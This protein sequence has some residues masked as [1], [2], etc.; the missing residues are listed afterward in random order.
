[1]DVPRANGD[2]EGADAANQAL[3]KKYP[4]HRRAKTAQLEAVQASMAKVI[5]LTLSSRY[6]TDSAVRAQMLAERERVYRTEVLAELDSNIGRLG[7]DAEKNPEDDAKVFERDRWEHYRLMAMLRCAKLLPEGSPEAKATYEKIVELAQKFVDT[8]FKNFGLQYEAQLV[9]GQSLGA[10]GRSQEA[11]EALELLVEVE[12]VS[13]PPYDDVMVRIIRLLRIQAV[14]GSAEAWNRAG[15]PEKAVDIFD[16][17]AKVPQPHFPWRKD[18]EDPDVLPFAVSM[19]IEEAIARLAGG[20][21]QQGV[22]KIR[23]L[24][25]RFD[26]PAFRKGNPEAADAYLL[27]IA[28]GLARAVDAGVADLP[29]ELYYRAAVGYKG[30]GR[31][32][33]A[34]RAATL[35]LDAGSGVPGEEFWLAASLY[36]IG[37]AYDSIDLPEAAALAYQTLCLDSIAKKSAPRFDVLLPDAAQNWYALAEELAAGQPGPWQEIATL[38][39][40]VFSELS[41]GEAGITLRLQKA[42]EAEDRGQ[43]DEARRLY[44]AIPRETEIDGRKKRVEAYYRARAG[45][46]R[47]GFRKAVAEGRAAEG[48]PELIAEVGPLITEARTEKDAAGEAALRFE[49]ANAHWTEP[50]RD[51]AAALAALSPLLGEVAGQNPF[52]EGGLLLWVTVLCWGNPEN[53]A[54]G[55]KPADA[56]RVLTALKGEFAESASVAIALYEMVEA[57]QAVGTTQAL[58]RAADLAIE[59]T[60]H[61]VAKF[62]EASPGVKLTIAKILVQGGEHE[63]ARLILADAEKAAGD[64]PLLRTLIVLQY[65]EAGNATGRHREVLESLEPFIAEHQDEIVMGDLE[66]APYLLFQ[67][68][69]ALVGLYEKDRKPETLVRAEKD[70]EGAVGILLQRRSSLIRTGQITPQFERDYWECYLQYLLVLQAQN[71][72]EAVLGMIQGERI[73]KGGAFAPAALQASFDQLEKDCQ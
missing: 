16:S 4:T 19:E 56:E 72:C 14:Q 37:E 8:R 57:N 1:V 26:A 50:K 49:L 23:K 40:G 42:A 41:S 45:A 3:A 71:R 36:E 35:A 28:E 53:P 66:E 2:I 43:Y 67:R 48:L 61:P 47:A 13:S 39:E 55:P 33:H 69:M 58:E 46:V 73:K 20:I 64:D 10:L 32:D 21:R 31:Y 52:R 60:R 63:P 54:D 18:P 11:A 34:I 30:Q 29:A 65:A 38:A 51:R 7:A 12:P 70:L 68:A 6:E 27:E 59:Y 9:L 62:A 44:L 15:R 24:I 17:I 5:S 22:D 25:D